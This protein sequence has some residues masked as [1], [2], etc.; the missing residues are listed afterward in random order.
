MNL[1]VLTNNPMRASFRQRIGAYLDILRTNGIDCKVAKLPA[2]P[3]ARR[4]LFK[5]AADFDGVFLHKK[6]LNSLDA[7]WL[8]KYSRKI[9]YNFDDAVMYSDKTPDHHSPSHFRGFRRS[10]T[11]A[12][13]VITGSSYLAEHALKL[14][15]NVKVLPIGLAVSDYK[16]DCPT[17]SDDKIRLVWIGSKSTLRYLDEIKPAFEEIGA[18]SDNV[19][20]RI[21]CDDFFDLQNMEVEKHLWSKESRAAELATS[22]IGLAPL[23]DNRFTRG[24][25]SFKVLEYG[26]AGLP[27]VASPVGTNSDYVLDGVTGLFTTNIEQWTDRITQLVKD[28]RLRKGMGEKARAHAKKF[29][30]SI[31]GKQLTDLINKLLKEQPPAI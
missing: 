24:K 3:L 1:F 14:N 2:G 18:R 13:M 25:C 23:P 9:I 26:A 30:I 6:G 8:R 12:D 27:V 20:L 29:D 16:T 21:I 31:I 15:H 10:V 17:K 4:R 5:K 22:D 19:L 7:F 28:P 11:L